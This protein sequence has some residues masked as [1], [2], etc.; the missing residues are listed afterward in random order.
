MRRRRTTTH[1]KGLYSQWEDPPKE[2][3]WLSAELEE[4]AVSRDL[5]EPPHVAPK[6]E[7]TQRKLYTG[8]IPGGDLST[9]IV[10]TR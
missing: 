10:S 5:E 8:Q 3:F 2:R 4:E 6:K 9:K 7:S 1:E